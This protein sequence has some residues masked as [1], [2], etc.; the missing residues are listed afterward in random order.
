MVHYFDIHAHPN[1]V[2][3]EADRDE[4]IRRALEAG[5][6]MNVVGTQ[7]ETSQKAV[8]LAERY[9]TGVY[10]TVGLH[11]IHTSKSF[12]DEKELGEGGKEFTSR[13]EL[14]DSTFYRK[15][16]DHPKVVAIGECGLD[17]YHDTNPR[18][19]TN[20][21]NQI[22]E[23]AFR[24]QIE[25]ALEVKKP[26]MLHLRNG[27]GR[28]AYNDAFRILE[29]C[30]LNHESTVKGN[31]HF[32]AGSVEEAKPF[33]DLGFSFSFTGVVTFARDYDDIV[34]YLPIDRIMAETDAPY[35]TPAP[36]RGKRNEP[37]YVREVVKAIAGIRGLSEEEVSTVLWQNARTFFGLL[38]PGKS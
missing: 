15:L 4:V 1:F 30:F 7:Q 18:M 13:G 21:T 25:L 14:F 35:V 6:W 24:A 37:L 5:V 33:L 28:S 10:A 26:L 16:A 3:F 20:A 22:Q 29:S 32:F 31:L 17:Y 34:R 8:L 11:P 38:S 27:S 12:H 2:A 9:P 23:Q 36:Y 19:G